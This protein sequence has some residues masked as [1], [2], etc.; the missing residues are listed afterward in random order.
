MTITKAIKESADNTEGFVNFARN[1]RGVDVAVMIKYTADEVTRVSMRSKRSNVSEIAQS[2]G[3]GGHIRA[4][5]AT[6][7]KNLAEAREIVL[8]AIVKGMEQQNA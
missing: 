4:A 6:V 2:I 8:N 7:Y 1:I 3:G 5:G